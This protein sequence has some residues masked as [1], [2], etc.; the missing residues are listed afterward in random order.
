MPE[1]VEEIGDAAFYGCTYLENLTLPSSVQS[2]GDNCFALCSKLQDITV[3][4]S[5]PPTIQAKTF[6]DVKRSIPVYVP[7][8]SETNYT[9][10]MYW[11]EF[12]IRTQGTDIKEV[13][14]NPSAAKDGKFLHDGQIYILRDG[15][16]YDLI[17]RKL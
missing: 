10:D 16:V 3:E 11:S 13:L 14:A 15:K 6:F 7:A 1:G 2:I 4:A 17:G 5:T 9:N 12:N 8:G